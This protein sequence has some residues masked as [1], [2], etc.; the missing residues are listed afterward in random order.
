MPKKKTKKICLLFAGG[1]TI[2]EKDIWD[3]SVNKAEDINNWLKQIPE[4]SLIA[5][6][7]PVFICAGERELSGIKL[8][9]K[10]S[11]QIYNNLN[12][13]DGFV[14]LFD[15]ETILFNGI[16]LSFAL[17][18]LNKPVILTGSQITSEAVKQ[19]DWQVKKA[20]A[21][22]GLGVK[23]NLINAVQV[24]TMEI[25]AVGLIFG[26]HCLRA[27]KAIRSA[28]NDLNIFASADERYL[29]KIDFGISPTEKFELPKAKLIL[30]NKFAPEVLNIKY[31]PGLD[32]KL[33]KS[34][35]QKSQGVLI[36]S[37]EGEPITTEFLTNLA[38]LKI[39][40]IIYNKLGL[41]RLYKKN[42]IEISNLTL[43]TTLIKF[44]W[45]L[46]QTNNLEE[47]RNLMYAEQCFEIID[48]NKKK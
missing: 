41:P 31:Y 44:K 43:P 35:L 48:F 34:S 36:E 2:D 38:K 11:Q 46:A 8:W 37:L 28:Y 13:Y 12:N 5:T 6:V 1:T 39:P 26:N 42:L 30:K 29:A 14:V 24:A 22:G 40:V 3:S 45:A 33:I 16:A 4:L 10:V 25:P 27:V 9:Q 47:L 20:K 7:N 17:L 23:S 18:N 19:P 15:T 32:F 21:Y